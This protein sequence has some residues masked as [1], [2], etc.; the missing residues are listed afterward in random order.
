MNT[1]DAEPATLSEMSGFDVVTC[2]TS[3][4]SLLA[5]IGVSFLIVP[6]IAG[7]FYGLA[8]LLVFFVLCVQV[9]TLLLAVGLPSLVMT[10]RHRMRLSRTARL[11]LALAV[12]G[13]AVEG[14]AL[15]LIPVTGSC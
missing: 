15:W 12:S 14:L 11:L 8:A 6:S 4:A 5:S 1:T 13:V 3:V 2:I 7:G 10:V 9:A